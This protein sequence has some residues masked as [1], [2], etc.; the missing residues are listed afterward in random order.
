MSDHIINADLPAH[1]REEFRNMAVSERLAVVGMSAAYV[2][3]YGM[4][5]GRVFIGPRPDCS[6]ET[7]HQVDDEITKM[8]SNYESE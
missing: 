8:I 3:F 6:I 7:L 1:P 5:D 2:S 4:K